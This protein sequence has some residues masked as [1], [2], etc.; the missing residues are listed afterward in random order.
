MSNQGSEVVWVIVLVE[1]GIPTFVEAYRDEETARRREEFL[2][3]DINLDYDETGVFEVEI[4]V[5]SPN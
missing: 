4:A 3:K 2:R 1:S 5:Q